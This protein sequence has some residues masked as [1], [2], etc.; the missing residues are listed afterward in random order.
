MPLNVGTARYVRAASGL[1]VRDGFNRP[2]SNTALGRAETGQVWTVGNAGDAATLPTFG[3]SGGK[4]IEVGAGTQND[5]HAWVDAGAS[6]GIRISCDVGVATA[7]SALNAGILFRRQDATNYLCL[8]LANSADTIAIFRNLA[9]VRSTVKSQAFA[10]VDGQ[11]VHLDILLQGPLIT[12]LANG[13]FQ[14]THSDA[15]FMATGTKHGL[16]TTGVTGVTWEN[17]EVVP[18]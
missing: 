16:Y 17:F 8:R 7:A 18:L 2:D 14:F 15:N 10:T 9:T 13:A 4:A 12:V 1:L 6:D 3:L 5:G 11:V